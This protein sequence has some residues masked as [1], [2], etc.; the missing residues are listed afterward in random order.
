MIQIEK[1]DKVRLKSIG[2]VM[3]V[4]AVEKNALSGQIIYI[5]CEWVSPKKK[6]YKERFKPEEVMLVRE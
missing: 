5:E 6:H 1:G 4:T 2:P 3:E